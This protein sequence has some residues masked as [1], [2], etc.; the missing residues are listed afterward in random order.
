M[1]KATRKA[2]GSFELRTSNFGRSSK[3]EPRSSKVKV[4]SP[5]LLGPCLL[6]LLLGGCAEFQRSP[7]NDDPLFNIG[8]KTKPPKTDG[9]PAASSAPVSAIPP[10]PAVNPSTSPAALASLPRSNG[11]DLRIPAPQQG[12]PGRDS[13]AGVPQGG[14]PPGAVLQP[15]L[16][17]SPTA[18]VQPPANS[19][20]PQPVS[21]HPPAANQSTPV[22]SALARPQAQP[23]SSE[24]KFKRTQDDLAARGAI[25]QRLEMTTGTGEWKF[26]CYVP[27]RQNPKVHR[28]YEARARDPLSA[29]QAVCDKIDQE[30]Q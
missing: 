14:P 24:D 23:L 28:A 18:P 10:L 12:A 11:D 27:N 20:P 5:N 21:L 4:P 2:G 22:A 30:Q 9:Q 25:G 29:I 1:G 16:N 13:W 15:P 6:A 8:S 19:I 17:G 3:L 7:N 26:S